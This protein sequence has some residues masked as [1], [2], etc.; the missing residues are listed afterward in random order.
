M[1]L[2]KALAS[3]PG[4]I[5][6]A[7]QHVFSI[8]GIHAWPPVLEPPEFWIE[9]FAVLADELNLPVQNLADAVR[10]VQTFITEVEDAQ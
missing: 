9:P 7:C 2:M 8:R 1:L 10:E 6:A 4:G 3:N 5:K